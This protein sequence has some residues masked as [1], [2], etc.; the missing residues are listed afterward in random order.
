VHNHRAGYRER[1]RPLL[2]RL[3]NRYWGKE[4]VPIRAR[5]SRFILILLVSAAPVV[6][7]GSIYKCTQADGSIT[8]SD[9]A[10][11]QDTVTREYKGEATSASGSEAGSSD[12]YSVMEQVRRIEK[13]ENAERKAAAKE[14]KGRDKGT[15]N[16]SRKRHQ[17]SALTYQE[18][19]K[20]ALAATGYHDYDN[21]SGMQRDR[22]DAEMEKFKHS[23]P[24]T[25]A[26]PVKPKVTRGKAGAN[27]PCT[28]KSGA[29]VG[30]GMI[31]ASDGTSCA[32]A[33]PDAALDTSTSR[34][35]PGR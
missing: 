16:S 26:K 3:I 29:P 13:R 23:P 32:P 9:V 34:A 24:R 2:S 12:H 19:K 8:L 6:H 31:G 28:G 20:K 15:H 5:L 4:E 35:L 30:G 17:E 27:K 18:A 10:C 22:V 25:E 11:P 14:Q 1:R 33:G 21:L 7:A